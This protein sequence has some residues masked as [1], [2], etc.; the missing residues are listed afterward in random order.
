[1]SKNVLLLLVFSFFT[2]MMGFSNETP[3]QKLLREAKREERERAINIYFYQSRSGGR[4]EKL[5]ALDKILNEW[6]KLLYT[7]EDKRLVD[8]AIYLAEEG[9]VRREYRDN[10]LI[11]N[12]P[13]VRKKAC[14]VLG[15]L[16]GDGA[17]DA[18][19]NILITDEDPEVRVEACNQ[20]AAVGDN[21][22]AEVLRTLVYIYR[23]TYRPEPRLVLALINAVKNV[24]RNSVSGYVDAVYVLTEIQMSNY[25]NHIRNAAKDAIDYLKAPPEKK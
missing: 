4:E 17:R 23:S 14:M 3:E 11:N 8:L 18:L 5:D 20:L 6:G 25:N 13:E 12:Y 21:S 10:M 1:M 9:T 16:G 7:Q 24:A 22:R 2:V 19:V 15:K